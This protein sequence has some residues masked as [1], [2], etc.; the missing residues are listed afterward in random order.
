[1]L[2]PKWNVPFNGLVL[3]SCSAS[4][5]PS[6]LGAKD[7]NKQQRSKRTDLI[8]LVHALA[9]PH[10][11]LAA[12]HLRHANVHGRHEADG[13]VVRLDEDDA[14]AGDV[15]DVGLG[16][17]RRGRVGV[18]VVVR[19]AFVPVLGVVR[20]GDVADFGHGAGDGGVPAMVGQRGEES[21]V[22]GAVGEELC[23]GLVVEHGLQRVRL[24][25]EVEGA[26]LLD[27]VMQVFN[28]GF[29][30]V[31]DYIFVVGRIVGTFDGAFV[32]LKFAGKELVPGFEAEGWGAWV[33]ALEE[34]SEG[35]VG[36]H[37]R[38]AGLRGVVGL[39]SELLQGFGAEPA[40][41]IIE[42]AR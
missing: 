9:L 12:R 4:V 17:V 3:S 39:G 23:L 15:R 13:G 22:D 29:A 42:C 2:P 28:R 14:T 41:D 34:L 31:D 6:L 33:R 40:L 25:L 18:L 19:E 30:R 20:P 27:V 10:G 1:M 8:A 11:K 16:P 26:P 5:N 35:V 21:L 32:P 7:R 37:G 36:G 38:G 24:V